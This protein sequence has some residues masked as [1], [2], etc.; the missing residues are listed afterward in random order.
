MPE[1]IQWQPPTEQLLISVSETLKSIPPVTPEAVVHLETAL[2]KTGT[3]IE[4][5]E[6]EEPR[7]ASTEGHLNMVDEII[8]AAKPATAEDDLHRLSIAL[9]ELSASS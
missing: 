3:G 1:Q 2:L 9:S 8:Y 7:V 5:L 4:I 6:T